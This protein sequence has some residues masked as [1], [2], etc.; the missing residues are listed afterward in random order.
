MTTKALKAATQIAIGVETT[1]GTSVART[2]R[3]LTRSATFRII[4]EQEAFEGHMHGTLARALLDPL[5][6]RTGTELELPLDVD[7][8]NILLPLLAGVKGDVTPT[9][10]GTGEARLWTFTPSPTV[11]VAP[12]TYSLE[13]VESD[14]AAAPTNLARL[15][16]YGFCTEFELSGAINVAPT[17]TLRMVARKSAA[18][19]KTTIALPTLTRAPSA[20]WNLFLDTTWAGLG[21]TQKTGQVY[22]FTYKF[23]PYI[24]PQFYLDGRAD[25]DF[26]QHEFGPRVADLTLDVAID[27]QAGSLPAAEMTAKDAKTKRFVELRLDGA[28]FVTPDTALARFIKLQ[29][30]YHHAADSLQDRG[31]DRDGNLVV[32]MHLQSVYDATGAADV[33]FIIQNNLATYG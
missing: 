25:A 4:D 15:A 30:A 3:L 21:T 19:T 32:R 14:F 27:T 10:P 7:F 17:M 18:S 2:R 5:T 12:K 29:G 6:V 1:P 8:E 16:A 31:S 9:T 28:A 20:R 13:W 26:V 22:G 24:F 33:R 11:V 23:G